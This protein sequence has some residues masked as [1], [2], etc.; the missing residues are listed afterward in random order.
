MTE[1]TYTYKIWFLPFLLGLLFM[2]DFRVNAANQSVIK[3]DRATLYIHK[4][5]YKNPNARPSYTENDGL[6]REVENE[7][8]TYGLNDVTFGIYDVTLPLAEKL[9]TRSLEDIQQ[10]VLAWDLDE[11]HH[12]LPGSQK[13]GSIKT[14]TINQESGLGRF[15]F[16]IP[17]VENPAIL[18]VEEDAPLI[19][20]EKIEYPAAPMLIVFPVENPMQSGSYLSEIHLYPKNYGYRVKETPPNKPVTPS[21]KPHKPSL[22]PQTGEAKTAITLIGF[23]IVVSVGVIGL[24]NKK[25][26][27]KHRRI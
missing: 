21:P 3:E 15:E 18:I 13:L 10:E 1:K 5:M 8:D 19:N 26:K 6:Q 23:V 17:E 7:S 14:K 2:T 11:T 4:R 25:I 27:K 24:R 9:K 20:G 22:L 16:T 12:P